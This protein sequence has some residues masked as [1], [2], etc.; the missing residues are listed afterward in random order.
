MKTDNVLRINGK[1]LNFE[2]HISDKN[3]KKIMELL[4]GQDDTIFVPD[5]IVIEN[6]ND[7]FGIVFMNQKQVLCYDKSC[8]I[9]KVT[10]HV[11]SDKIKCK[12][13]PINKEDMVVGKIYFETNIKKE[14]IDFN[15]QPS[16]FI[17]LGNDKQVYNEDGGVYIGFCYN[18]YHYEVVP[19]KEN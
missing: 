8:N 7:G 5:N 13:V 3:I 17:Y 12:L 6:M 16:Y 19:I 11:R 9:W 1:E 4:K 10:S 2:V 14:Y 15:Y 18:K